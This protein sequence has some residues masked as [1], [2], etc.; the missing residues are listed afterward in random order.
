MKIV[1][2]VLVEYENIEGT[3]IY[4]PNG[5]SEFTDSELEMFVKLYEHETV[6]II[7][8]YDRYAVWYDLGD[9]LNDYLEP[10]EFVVETMEEIKAYI[11]EIIS[12]NLSGRLA[13]SYIEDVSKITTPKELEELLIELESDDMHMEEIDIANEMFIRRII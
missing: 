10:K 11:I 4:C 13:K 9:F 12:R 6:F 2:R 5:A 7:K 1:N 8:N 3:E